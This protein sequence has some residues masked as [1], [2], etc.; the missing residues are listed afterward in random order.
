MGILGD[1]WVLDGQDLD[2]FGVGESEMQYLCGV[3]LFDTVFEGGVH[4]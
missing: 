3:L 2:D 1:F 4:L